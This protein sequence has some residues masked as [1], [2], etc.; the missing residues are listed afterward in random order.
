LLLD[1][2]ILAGYDNEKIEKQDPT[3]SPQSGDSQRTRESALRTSP[4]SADGFFFP[5]VFDL[6]YSNQAA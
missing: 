4:P 6:D 3:S 5:T 2:L 1:C